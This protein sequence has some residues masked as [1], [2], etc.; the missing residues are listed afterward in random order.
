MQDAIGC[1]F[2]GGKRDGAS[3]VIGLT[4][5][6]FIIG[7]THGELGRCRQAKGFKPCGWADGDDVGSC[8]R[9][10]F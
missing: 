1:L 5:D 6:G 10:V 9:V 3:R 8:G 7:R 2:H 4:G